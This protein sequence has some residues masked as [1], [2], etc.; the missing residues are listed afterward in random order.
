RVNQPN[1]CFDDAFFARDIR[2]EDAELVCAKS[3]DAALSARHRI[4]PLG[5]LLQ[6]AVTCA[7]S[8]K[9]A[10]RLEAIHIEDND[11]KRRQGVEMRSDQTSD[12]VG[13]TLRV[14]KPGQ[15]IAE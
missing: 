11:S 1:D 6:N 3:S 14:I 15:W 7:A 8:E 5:R 9:I 2:Q 4:E 12:S 13:K 10:Y